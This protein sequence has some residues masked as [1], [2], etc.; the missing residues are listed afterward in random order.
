M[1]PRQ[2]FCPYCGARIHEDVR[3]CPVCGRRLRSE[4]CCRRFP[5]LHFRQ[6][7]RL[8][9]RVPTCSTSGL[10]SHVVQQKSSSEQTVNRRYASV[11]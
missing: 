7:V 4:R 1:P 3:V 8:P 10:C 2:R 5:H 9:V 6:S 11:G